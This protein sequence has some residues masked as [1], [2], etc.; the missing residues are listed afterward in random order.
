MSMKLKTKKELNYR[1]GST[2]HDCSECNHFIG[3]FAV[4]DNAGGLIRHEPR[5]AVIGLGNER[6]YKINRKYICDAHDNSQ[7]MAA[8][9]WTS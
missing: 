6:A 1:P 2:A 7:R 8:Y 3:V 4:K 9:R 5:C